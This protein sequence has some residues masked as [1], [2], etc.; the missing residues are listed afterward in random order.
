MKNRLVL[1]VCVIILNCLSCSQEDA[2]DK[3]MDE[4]MREADFHLDSDIEEKVS[5]RYYE[6]D[7]E[8]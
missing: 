8:R 7:S 4:A 2:L 5:I 6:E 3:A 1:V